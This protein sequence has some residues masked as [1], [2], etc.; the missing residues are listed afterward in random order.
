M[1]KKKPEPTVTPTAPT[2]PT[3][4][5]LDAADLTTAPLVVSAVVDP[6]P[7]P[8]EPDQAI[9]IEAPAT[10]EADGQAQD[11]EPVSEHVE[12]TIDN[13]V[14]VGDEFDGVTVAGF[15]AT[16]MLVT[17]EAPEGSCFEPDGDVRLGTDGPFFHHIPLVAAQARKDKWDARL[18]G[19]KSTVWPARQ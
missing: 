11:V 3:P 8:T 16:T 5:T 18:R 2:A 1:S 7:D 13:A 9:Q 17:L 12:C 4:T 6:T 19:E 10:I 15:D 14:K